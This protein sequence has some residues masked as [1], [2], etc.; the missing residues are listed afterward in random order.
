MYN[1]DISMLLNNTFENGIIANF[2]IPTCA[3]NTVSHKFPY[4]LII[5]NRVRILVTSKPIFLLKFSL[6]HTKF[7]EF[8]EYVK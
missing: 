4:I 3:V 1:D 7:L 2:V 8:S 6:T 5:S